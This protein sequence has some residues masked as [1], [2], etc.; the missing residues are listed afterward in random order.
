MGCA[1][2]GSKRNN[3]MRPRKQ[4][5]TT[6]DFPVY[7]IDGNKISE[8]YKKNK[9]KEYTLNRENMKMRMMETPNHNMRIGF[10]SRSIKNIK[11][12]D[13]CVSSV[14]LMSFSGKNIFIVTKKNG[15]SISKYMIRLI[16]N[17]ALKFKNLGFYIVP[18]ESTKFKSFKLKD[19]ISILFV[20]DSN[21]TNVVEGFNNKIYG[22]IEKFSNN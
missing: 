1:G 5:S 3:G 13:C 10:V 20:K 9:E 2:C 4:F 21:V 14:D 11:S 8:S 16:D 15:S 7:D 12:I 22:E 17:I 18:E 19:G 6:L